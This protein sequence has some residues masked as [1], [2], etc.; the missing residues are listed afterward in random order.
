MGPNV[1]FDKSFLQILT[2]NEA[3]LFD[4]Y[5][6]ATIVPTFYFE[7]L[8]DLAKEDGKSPDKV[9]MALANKSP[10][11][12]S[13][14]TAYFRDLVAWEIAGAQIDMSMRPHVMGGHTALANG[15]LSVDFKQMP[16]HVAFDR[17]QRGD[18]H[19]VER[20]FAKQ[21]RTAV[22]NIN[23][24]KVAEAVKSVKDLI[25]A[26]ANQEDARKAAAAFIDAPQRQAAVLKHI[27]ETAGLASGVFARAMARWEKA[28]RPPIRHFLPYGSFVLEIDI[29][30]EIAVM[31][32]FVSTRPSNQI[33]LTYLYY[34]PF[35]HI[36]VSR[37]KLHSRIVP[38]FLTDAQKFIW[39]D[40]LKADLGALH[41][42]L[43]QLPVEILEQGLMK[44][45]KAPPLDHAGV[46]SSLWDW[47]NPSWRN[48]QETVLSPQSEAKILAE[49]RSLQRAHAEA[50]RA[51]P[52]QYAGREPDY[53]RL[54]RSLPR[55]IGDY[56][57]L[58]K[59]YAESH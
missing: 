54:E 3:A 44:I 10:R 19:G 12:H 28:G 40:D 51:R 2:T 41:T 39:G 9:V 1:V 36:F 57:T 38:L 42:T 37:D 6:T 14:P 17:W 20:A 22:A 5:F 13:Y 23:L 43:S 47:F 55:K 52:Q 11:Q 34:L 35:G 27:V 53:I 50:P 48:K 21:W 4:N 33:D 56:Y 59:D 7:V 15:K 58:P 18:F 16:E 49:I 29:F 31:K 45:A 32:S 24:K 26:V 8:G 30:F 46:V 25:G